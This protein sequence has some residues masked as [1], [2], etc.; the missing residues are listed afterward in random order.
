MTAVLL[1][2]GRCDTNAKHAFLCVLEIG[3]NMRCGKEHVVDQQSV[4]VN[5]NNGCFCK[6]R[7][8]GFRMLP[9]IDRFEDSNRSTGLNHTHG[10]VAN[11]SVFFPE[12]DPVNLINRIPD[13]FVMRM[14]RV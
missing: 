12:L 13:T 2:H 10:N 4:G 14:I 8:S 9:L 5:G 6:L 7:F 1:L 3:S 11:R